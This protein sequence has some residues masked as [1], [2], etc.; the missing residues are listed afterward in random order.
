M[1]KNRKNTFLDKLV[2]FFN[3]IAVATLLLSYLATV[4]SP[5]KYWHFAFLGLAY[6]FILLANILF[7]F[8]WALKRRW[9]VFLSLC[10]IIVGFNNINRTI[11]IRKKT[12][13][14]H[15]RDSSSIKLMTYNIHHF[16]KLGSEVDSNAR[17]NILE[18]IN[19]EQPD[20]IALQEFLTRKKG[21]LKSENNILKILNTKD[22]YFYG[23]SGNDYESMG[24]AIFSKL[25]IITHGNLT[26]L[27][28]KGAN[29]GLW[30]DVKKNG[31]IFRIYT[32]HL[33]SIAFAPVDY[34]YFNRISNMNTEDE[35]IKHGKKILSRLKSAFIRRAK[36]V[37]ILKAY[38]DSCKTPYIIM[39]DFNDTPVSY[40]VT[41]ISKGLKNTFIE[42]GQG[43]GRTYNGDFPN[44]QIDYILAT[45]DFNI[46]TY[47]TVKK[48]YSD[49][50]PVISEVSLNSQ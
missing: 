26:K 39:G 30:I 49:H 34:Y 47:K 13:Q 31:K 2:L 4:I 16:K 19:E 18:L 40:C 12:V 23:T 6:P 9:Y 25:P 17:N 15:T 42:K 10:A 38:T 11:G 41:Q 5:E 21:K 24:I 1:K 37:D 27:D 48:S 46:H 29:N 22:Y 8:F 44:F 28:P 20:V 7:I 50:Y 32:V 14:D 33:A 3:L 45:Q 36:Q 35:D 43:I